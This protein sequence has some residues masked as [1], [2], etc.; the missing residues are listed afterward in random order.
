MVM[1]PHSHWVWSARYNQFHDQLVLSAGSDSRV[2]LSN[3][4]SL[5]SDLYVISLNCFGFCNCDC[6]LVRVGRTQDFGFHSR[7]DNAT[8][9]SKSTSDCGGSLRARLCGCV[10]FKSHDLHHQL[11]TDFPLH[12]SPTPV[13]FAFTSVVSTGTGTLRLTKTRMT[14]R[15]LHR[16]QMVK[17]HLMTSMKIACTRWNGLQQT[18]GCL[19]RS[20]LTAGWLLIEFQEISSTKF[21]CEIKRRTCWSFQLKL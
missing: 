18:L 14:K 16:S 8:I 12:A 10:V 17:L 19:H 9:Q 7:V 11:A 1:A 3:M 5:S 2:V 15:V 21:S 6:D 20:R 4:A 13:Q